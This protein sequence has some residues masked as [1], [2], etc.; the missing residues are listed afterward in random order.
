M[1]ILTRKQG[2]TITVGDNIQIHVM[3]V[4]GKQVRIGVVAPKEQ[5][6]LRGELLAD[7]I[8]ELK[9]VSK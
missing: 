1:L 6:I 9:K 5:K 4:K 3:E 2:Q 7:P 8:F